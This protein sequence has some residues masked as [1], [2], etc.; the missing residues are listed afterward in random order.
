MDRFLTINKLQKVFEMKEEWRL[1]CVD[2]SIFENMGAFVFIYSPDGKIHYANTLVSQRLG[3]SLDEIDRMWIHHFYKHENQ[4]ELI[5]KFCSPLIDGEIRTIKYP[6][7]S[8]DGSHVQIETWLSIANTTPQGI[9]TILAVGREKAS[10]NAEEVLSERES[11][12]LEERRMLSKI[13]EQNPYAIAIFDD[14]GFYLHGNQAYKDLWECEPPENYSIFTDPLIESQEILEEVNH[15]ILSGGI[16]RSGDIFYNTH[17]LDPRLPDKPMYIQATIFSI[18]DSNNNLKYSVFIYDDVTERKKAEM[19]LSDYKDH[20]ESV[21]NQRTH[22]LKKKHIQLQEKV[23]NE[24]TLSKITSRFTGDFNLD[25][26]IQN[27]LADLGTLCKASKVFLSFIDIENETGIDK[28]EWVPE[29]GINLNLSYEI[30]PYPAKLWW[31]SQLSN[32]NF[33]SISDVSQLPPEANVERAILE[34]SSIKAILAYAIRK[35]EKIIGFVGINNTKSVVHWSDSTK[36]SIRVFADLLG[37][38]YERI[39]IENALVQERRRLTSIVEYNPYAIAMFDPN[40]KFIRS[41]NA[42]GVL[43]GYEISPGYSIYEDQNFSNLEQ[44]NQ[45]HLEIKKGNVVKIPRIN[46]NPSLS[47]SALEDKNFVLRAAIFPIFSLEGELETIVAM[48]EDITKQIEAEQALEKTQRD[49]KDVIENTLDISYRINLQTSKYDYISPVAEKITGYS[50]HDVSTEHFYSHI[51]PEDAIIAQQELQEALKKTKSLSITFTSEGRFQC[52]NGDWIWLSDKYTHFSDAD[53]TPLYSIGTIRDITRRKND[54]LALLERE[55][56]FRQLVEH[57]P[58]PIVLLG[59]DNHVDY[60]NSEFSYSFGYI[61]ED[62]PSIDSLFQQTLPSIDY[63]QEI[64]QK[65]PSELD[66]SKVRLIP[67]KSY[68][69]TCKDSSYRKINLR[70]SFLESGLKYLIYEDITQSAETL[71]KLTTSEMLYRSVVETSQDLIFVFSKD[72][73]ITFANSAT[74]KKLGY[75]F[76]ELKQKKPMDFVHPEDYEKTKIALKPL[77]KNLSVDA[78]EYRIVKKNGNFLYISTNAVPLYDAAGNAISVL[79]VSRDITAMKKVQKSLREREL[80]IQYSNVIS[81]ISSML[82]PDSENT[83]EKIEGVLR[84]VGNSIGGSFIII[85]KHNGHFHNCKYHVEGSWSSS[86][87]QF[88]QRRIEEFFSEG[89]FDEY[90]E[91]VPLNIFATL[92]SSTLSPTLKDKADQ[93]DIASMLMLPV[94]LGKER[95]GTMILNSS[96]PERE[97]NQREKSLCLNVA[98]LVGLSLKTQYDREVFSNIFEALSA[99]DVAVYILQETKTKQY[100]FYYANSYFC[101]MVGYSLEDLLALDSYADIFPEIENKIIADYAGARKKNAP[102]PK[103][104]QMDIQTKDGMVPKLITLSW[105]VVDQTPAVFG[106]MFPPGSGAVMS[107]EE[108]YQKYAELYG[109]SLN[110]RQQT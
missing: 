89:V 60:I 99:M 91:S 18:F 67:P 43:L 62:F 101:E 26:S 94:F 29:T 83:S 103:Q 34:K 46:L 88:D 102:L 20:L 6:L 72:E 93:L 107:A 80:Q 1:N 66:E 25:D 85:L 56:K 4:E 42:L 12:F 77:R 9:Q 40:L 21:I 55:H 51:H 63:E 73:T 47:N 106:I 38:T 19:E 87:Y 78:V 71:E 58:F 69:C 15:A 10:L 75:T 110:Q 2:P 82:V 59:K 3:Y 5:K 16:Y 74:L 98:L 30:G 13:I 53:G 64:F 37:S 48:F 70:I 97:Y 31:H 68:T 32:M 95:F 57:S 81:M 84:T 28:Y 61:L 104:T 27:S 86:N 39:D 23:I 90:A 108:Y 50:L 92:N 24:Q 76:A 96:D 65:F 33:V 109:K 41:N 36:T 54:Q 49:F 100:K 45:Y 105:G 11:E 35:K 44:L 8:K 22:E 7:K 14:D 79:G 17:D 52:K